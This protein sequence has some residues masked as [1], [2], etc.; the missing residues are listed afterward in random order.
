MADEYVTLDNT[1]KCLKRLK[2][3]S[4]CCKKKMTKMEKISRVIMLL[5]L[6]R[7]VGVMLQKVMTSIQTNM[8]N[9]L[10]L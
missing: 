1:T 8:K 4:F 10:M 9:D 5:Y 2:C 7:V 3:F 6:L